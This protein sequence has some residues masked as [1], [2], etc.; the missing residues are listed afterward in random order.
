MTNS[1]DWPINQPG[2]FTRLDVPTD[3]L[4]SYH[5]FKDIDMAQIASW[6]TRIIGDSGAFSAMSSGK[7]IDRE[8]FHEWVD[9]WQEHLFWVAALDVIGDPDA[10]FENYRAAQRDGLNLVPTL[11]YGEEPDQM[12][13]LVEHGAS[14][15]GL[16]GMVPYSS[17]KDRLM[18]WTLSMHR[19]ARDNHPQVR[20]HGW[21]ISHPYLVD[22]LPWWSTD[23]SG[24]SSCFRFGTLRLWVPRRGRF[25]SVDLNGRDIARHA[26]LLREVYGIDWKLISESK[27]ENRR[28]L[29][30]VALRSVQLYAAWLQS[31]QQ[32]SAPALLLPKLEGQRGP[33]QVG[34]V[35]VGKDSVPV[36]PERE[37]WPGRVRG[38]RAVA[39]LGAPEMQPVKALHPENISPAKSPLAAAAQT[40]PGTAQNLAIEPTD[41]G[42]GPRS[43]AAMGMAPGAHGYALTPDGKAVTKQGPLQVVAD[44]TTLPPHLAPDFAKETP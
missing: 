25:V 20:F 23:S 10:S 39:A 11:H 35:G 15:I 31:R 7:P 24:F 29:G 8:E 30:R 32:V 9:R 17:E 12:D 41:A 26:K 27:S 2:D 42:R 38:P 43:V 3:I 13:R 28:E 44:T 36:S 18:R 33:L 34:A 1:G 21:G 4:C 19:Y 6:G 5:Y 14:L 22:N 40:Y 37:S 16:G